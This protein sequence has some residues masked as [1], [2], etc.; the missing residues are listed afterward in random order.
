MNLMFATFEE[1]KAFLNNFDVRSLEEILGRL[2]IL[3]SHTD[4]ASFEN[5]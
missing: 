5:Q 4:L 3:R 2:H 1:K